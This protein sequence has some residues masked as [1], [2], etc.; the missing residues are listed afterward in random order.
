MSKAVDQALAF[1]RRAIRAEA[2]NERLRRALASIKARCD[3][4]VAGEFGGLTAAIDMSNEVRRA[5]R[6]TETGEQ[7]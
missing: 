4:I 7:R 5:L 1:Q 2:E 3:R 6:P